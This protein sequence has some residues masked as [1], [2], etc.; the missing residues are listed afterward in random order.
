MAR[1]KAHERE[2]DHRDDPSLDD[3]DSIASDLKI[4]LHGLRR[5]FDRAV[6]VEWIRLKT[7]ILDSGIGAALYLFLFGFCLIIVF[8]SAAFLANAVRD[9]LG[10]LGAGFAILGA[11][12]ALILGFRAYVRASGLKKARRALEEEEYS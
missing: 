6:K 1:G 3:L 12:L 9:A 5:S 2:C 10:N 11:V 7:R 4:D 8:S